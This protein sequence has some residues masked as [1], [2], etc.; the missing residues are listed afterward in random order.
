MEL[1][2]QLTAAQAAD[3]NNPSDVMKFIAPAAAAACQ[4]KHSFEWDGEELIETK[5][6]NWG[7]PYPARGMEET[8]A[9][10]TPSS[11]GI[12]TTGKKCESTLTIKFR[13]TSYSF[14]EK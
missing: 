7:T 12:I 9:T 8:V 4:P 2:W 11:W 3:I 10:Y 1:K 5:D 14:Y 13:L 6:P